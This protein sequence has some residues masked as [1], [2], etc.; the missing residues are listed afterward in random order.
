MLVRMAI[1]RGNLTHENKDAF[2]H[3]VTTKMLPL[4][5]DFPEISSADALF[6]NAS[7]PSLED[8]LLILDMRYA[9]EGAMNKALASPQ[10]ARNAEETKTLLALVSNPS[11]EHVVLA[12]RS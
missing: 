4:I 9:D 11:V 8:V 1:F 12:P 2:I 7:D 3:Q 5:R 10:R 6:P